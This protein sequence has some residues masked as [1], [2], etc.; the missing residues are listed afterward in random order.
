MDGCRYEELEHTSEV[1]V[2]VFARDANELFVCT[3]QAMF[4][5]LQL[6]PDPGATVVTH[7]VAVESY[8]V[9]SLMVDWLGELLYL[10][11]TS[12]LAITSCEV[13]TELPTRLEAQVTL[14]KPQESPTMHIKAVTYHQLCVI[15]SEDGWRAEVFF[16]I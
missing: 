8:D 9:A 15:E 11:E 12:G 13:D 1:G 5:L 6:R 14:H 2:R 3:A 10:H 7:H 4:A 16:D